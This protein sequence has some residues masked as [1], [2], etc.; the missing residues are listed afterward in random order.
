MKTGKQI[1][2]LA[3]VGLAALAAPA[4][5]QE[6]P[7]ESAAVADDP[8]SS[9]DDVPV[10]GEIIVTAQ[11]R[12]QSQQDVPISISV[13]SAKA[14]EQSNLTT[15]ADIQFLSPGVNY[16]ANFGGG[17]NVR[18]VGTQSL[19][20]SAEQSVALVIDDVIQ[21]LPEV[22]FA[23]PSYQSLVDIERI[24][25]LKGPQ[26]TLFGKNSSAGVIQIITANPE[27][28]VRSLEGSL[29][30]GTK[31]ELNAESVLNLP[32]GS[33]AALRIAGGLQ[34]RDGFVPDLYSGEDRWAY[35]RY[36]LRGKLL[37]EPTDDL[38]I[39]LNAEYRHLTDNANGLW[40]FRNC[41]SGFGAFDP[42]A[43]VEPYGIEAGPENLEV[44]TDGNSYTKQE[45]Y[46]FSGR[47][48]YDIGNATLTSI[49]AYRDLLQPI[50]LDT[51][52]TPAA[53]YSRNENVS[54]G[55]QFTQELRL[56]GEAGI[57]NYTVGG[58]YYDARPYQ[59][60]M[61]GGTLGYLPDD[62]PILLSLNAIGPYSGQGYGSWVKAKIKSYALF[63]QLEAEV[64]PGLTFIAG[65]RY[66]NDDVRQTIDY[67]DV[68]WLCRAAYAFG[69]PCHGMD[70]PLSSGEAQVK[71]DKFTYK[72]TA[73]YDITPAVNIY[74]TYATGYKGPMIS[75]PAN[76]P[77]LL[78][79]PELSKS[80][81]VG[82]K[83]ELFARA[84]AF[85]LA[86]FKVDYDD[87]QG[88]QR[89]GVAPT[90]YYTTTNAGGL[91]TKGVEADLTW[92]A[93]PGLT[94]AGNVSYIPTKFTEFAVQCYDR[95]TNPATTPGECNYVQPGLPADAP[96]QFNAA[97]Y[98]LIYSPKWTWGAT[99]NYEAYVGEG[100][101]F[102]VGA[103]YSYRSSSYGVVADPNSI[104]PGYG[105]LNGQMSIG[106]SDDRWRVALFARN[107]LDKHFVAGIFRT[108]LDSG[109]DNST[110]LS[111]IGYSNIPALD[112]SRTVGIKFSYSFGE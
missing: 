51:D 28:G 58:F 46:S 81:E 18:G 89:V 84:L 43:T 78:L 100:L 106:D 97:G 16:N 26:G 27:I 8:A 83:A 22:S 74:A 44:A 35:Q 87:F 71:A 98:P 5:A 55:T 104:N 25:V 75:H 31:N 70:L 67:F 65:G 90:F 109:T 30:Y 47:I 85:N 88:Q 34:R 63:G 45:A 4:V 12:E 21:G 13:V 62:S 111:T 39:L 64:V 82:L 49:T 7:D 73:K 95:Y 50:S 99:A 11:R 107:L 108:P 41:G 66:T 91:Q 48:D 40:T 72:L 57:L 69:Q 76:Q 38:S 1:A 112:S 10:P 17:F 20:M 24:E 93:A 92:R 3:G 52:A 54:G 15:V 19:L 56:N 14:L 110:P 102:D 61:N 32:L 68:P 36:S 86:L 79:R 23:G 53:I 94:L 60:G 2:L 42:C 9:D 37:W 59:K 103:S 33:T 29:S 96:P 80:Y 105:L 77:Q 6:A 101:S